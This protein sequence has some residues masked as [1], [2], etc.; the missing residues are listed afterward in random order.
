M[1]R[2]Y[3]NEDFDKLEMNGY[4]DPELYGDRLRLMLEAYNS[5]TMETEGKVMAIISFREYT[6]GCYSA[7]VLCSTLLEG[8]HTKELKV[9]IQGCIEALEAI[10]VETLSLKDDV[11]DRF[12]R[13]LGFSLE[14]TKVKFFN[15]KDYNM[16]AWVGGNN[17][18]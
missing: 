13:F 16:W 4:I 2:E 12:H 15:N 11:I 8:K 9:F 5:Y 18:S 1:I 3:V 14:G 10:R 7:F 6:R 17:G